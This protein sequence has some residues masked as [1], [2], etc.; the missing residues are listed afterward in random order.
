MAITKRKSGE[1][2]RVTYEGRSVV[3][4]A[5]LLRSR[6]A[7][8]NILNEKIRNTESAPTGMQDDCAVRPQNHK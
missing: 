1:F 5:R 8:L 7:E 3:D 6:A 2:S 4:T